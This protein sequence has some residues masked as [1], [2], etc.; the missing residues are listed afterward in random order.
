MLC[1]SKR[2]HKINKDKAF[3]EKLVENHTGKEIATIFGC[4][5]ALVSL[6][7]KKMGIVNHR[8]RYNHPDLSP[9]PELSYL[10]GVYVGDGSISKSGCDYTIALSAKDVEFVAKFTKIIR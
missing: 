6:H 4:S 8:R 7:L 2:K 10:I 3:L 9:S 1:M 5:E